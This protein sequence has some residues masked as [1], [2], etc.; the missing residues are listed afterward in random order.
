MNDFDFLDNEKCLQK[1]IKKL[2]E[3][4]TEMDIK[5]YIKIL[6]FSYTKDKSDLIYHSHLNDHFY[7]EEDISLSDYFGVCENDKEEEI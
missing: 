6:E 7:Y 5:D 1:V 3:T 2:F 4:K